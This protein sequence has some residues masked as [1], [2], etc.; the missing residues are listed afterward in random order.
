VDQQSLAAE[1]VRLLGMRAPRYSGSG[2]KD[3]VLRFVDGDLGSWIRRRKPATDAIIK[4]YEQAR[5]GA[6]N[7][8]YAATLSS[9]IAELHVELCREFIAGGQS[10]MPPSVSGDAKLRKAYTT[11]LVGAVF[12]RLKLAARAAADCLEQAPTGDRELVSRCKTIRTDIE[13]ISCP[14]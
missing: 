8:S 14:R 12:D 4:K 5:R 10:A 1:K 6:K 3:D 11:A 13:G 7:A 2:E 9:D